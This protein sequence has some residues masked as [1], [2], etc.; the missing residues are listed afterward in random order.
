MESWN[1]KNLNWVQDQFFN[2]W[3]FDI[4]REW[5]RRK[6]DQL[7]DILDPP[8]TDNPIRALVRSAMFG[9][10]EDLPKKE[11]LQLLRS[12]DMVHFGENELLHRREAPLWFE[13]N[14]KN[15]L[16]SAMQRIIK[17]RG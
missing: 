4:V 13:Y 15:H 7:R 8:P 16:G 6:E 10:P 12:W 14:Y 5:T 2:V 17:S 9:H 11:S 3:K 1:W